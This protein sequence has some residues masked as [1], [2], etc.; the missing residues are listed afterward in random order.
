MAFLFFLGFI[1]SAL[2]KGFCPLYS[3]NVFVLALL[4]TEL[5]LFQVDDIAIGDDGNGD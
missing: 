1:F 3:K 4:E 2:L 5:E